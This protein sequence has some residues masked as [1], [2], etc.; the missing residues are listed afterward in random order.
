MY[1]KG[2][3]V[4]IYTRVELQLLVGLIGTTA[5]MGMH[6]G[7]WGSVLVRESNTHCDNELLTMID[8][9]LHLT[10]EILLYD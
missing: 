10:T 1:N 9:C 5:L 8:A 2:T 6:I 7:S 4:Y 3:G